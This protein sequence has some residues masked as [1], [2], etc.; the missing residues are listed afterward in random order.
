MI[1]LDLLDQIPLRHVH[2]KRWDETIFLNNTKTNEIKK[3][4][5]QQTRKNKTKQ[6]KKFKVKVN[7]R[8]F[9]LRM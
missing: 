6:R 2:L 4:Q 3:K 8:E 1:I 5:Q 7:L 9:Y